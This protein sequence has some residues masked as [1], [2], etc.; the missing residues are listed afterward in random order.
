MKEESPTGT[1]HETKL[2]SRAEEAR[3]LA[4]EA[5]EEI[6]HG[7]KEEGEFLMAEARSLDPA[8]VKESG[9]AKENGKP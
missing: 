9:S 7:N 3:S 4:R 1:H 2:P 8:A 5:A 6:K